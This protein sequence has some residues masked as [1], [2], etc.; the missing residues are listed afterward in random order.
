MIHC[1]IPSPIP[2]FETYPANNLTNLRRTLAFAVLEHWARAVGRPFQ[3]E[4]ESG[5]DA[6]LIPN[7]RLSHLE[8]RD[9]EFGGL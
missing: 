9:V 2:N 8:I 1:P 7:G 4:S 6:D 5:N 3:E